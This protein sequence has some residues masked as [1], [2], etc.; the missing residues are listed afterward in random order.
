MR[1]LFCVHQNLSSSSRCVPFPCFH[2]H[3]PMF[4]FRRRVGRLWCAHVR[5]TSVMSSLRAW[6]PLWAWSLGW[7][8]C[9]P[10]TSP[11]WC[12]RCSSQYSGTCCRRRCLVCLLFVCLFVCCDLSPPLPRTTLPPRQR[13]SAYWLVCWCKVR[14]S[15]SL[16]WSK[17]PLRHRNQSVPTTTF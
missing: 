17:W 5:P 2:S 12:S 10:P 11:S 8:T 1:T 6:W 14:L 7:R 13:T 15:S 9:S 3:D 4:P 16:S